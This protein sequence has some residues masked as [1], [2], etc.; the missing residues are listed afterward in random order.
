MEWNDQKVLITGIDGFIG[1]HLAKKL[2]GM[3]ANVCGILHRSLGDNSPLLLQK[4]ENKVNTVI[5]DVSDTEFVKRAIQTFQPHWIFHLAAQSIVSE[6]Q[7][8]PF[9]T[10]ETN[11]RGTYNI[12]SSVHDLSDFMGIIV[13][14]SD[15]AYG[16]AK[17]LPLIEKMPL[18]GGSIYDTSKAC[19]DLIACSYS[20]LHNIPLGVTRCANTYGP[21]DLHFSRI[22]PDTMR[23]ILR[24]NAPTIRGDGSHERDYIFISDIVDGYL[25]VANYLGKTRLPGEAFNLGTG[26]GTTVIELVDHILRINGKHH[27]KPIILGEDKPVEIKNQYLDAKKA[28]ELLSWHPTVTLSDG[29]SITYQWYRDYFS[30]NGV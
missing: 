25:Q 28:S 27:L 24:G 13:A 11:V 23:E 20:K 18:L 12:I 2:V 10:F 4:I 16:N 3:K 15:K 7:K 6:G 21:V 9:Y 1:S 14:S 26:Q 22:I 8:N 29:L 19:A 5:G 17:E 30:S